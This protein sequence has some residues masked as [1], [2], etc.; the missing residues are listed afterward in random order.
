MNQ[1]KNIFN[2]TCCLILVL[3]WVK[4]NISSFLSTYCFLFRFFLSGFLNFSM[5]LIFIHFLVS[6]S[7]YF[8]RG[9]LLLI[10]KQT[11]IQIFICSG[12]IW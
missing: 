12:D 9:R 10:T 4:M 2:F 3:K 7:T 1:K 11:F 8:L 6:F 5:F